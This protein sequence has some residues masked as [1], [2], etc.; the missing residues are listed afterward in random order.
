MKTKTVVTWVLR[1]LLGALFILSSVPKLTSAQVSTDMF[2]TLGAEPW[3]RYITGLLELSTGVLLLIPK[4]GRYGALLGLIPMLGAIVTHIAVLG[5][6]FP[7]PMAVVFAILC[8]VI[9]YL[10]GGLRG[11]TVAGQPI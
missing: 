10:L 8:V 1:I 3:L 11:A 5:F 2:R 7:F 4:T 6:G 9:L